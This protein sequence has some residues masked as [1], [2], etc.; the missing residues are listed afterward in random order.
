[1]RRCVRSYH[2][3]SVE[4][5]VGQRDRS[6]RRARPSTGAG[7]R[8]AARGVPSPGRTGRSS[9][10]PLP[11]PVR[12]HRCRAAI[13]TQPLRQRATRIALDGRLPA[14]RHRPWLEYARPKPEASGS[15]SISR[16]QAPDPAPGS[17]SIVIE[18]ARSAGRPDG[19]RV[20]LRQPCPAPA[21]M[22]RTR[23]FLALR[24][25]APPG[26]CHG[27]SRKARSGPPRSVTSRTGAEKPR[28]SD[29]VGL[30]GILSKSIPGA[31]A[32]QLQNPLG[33]AVIVERHGAWPSGPISDEADRDQCSGAF[34]GW[35]GVGAVDSG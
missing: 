22:A 29:G 19:F 8:C 3:A 25:S 33:R 10:S 14:P 11:G 4:L 26:R 27:R 1:M 13:V 12:G 34:S 21:N 30:A 31:G 15:I 32:F 7:W 35:P 16:A 2:F 18:R 6:P 5:P 20:R 23:Q 28:S 9:L 17:S 24:P